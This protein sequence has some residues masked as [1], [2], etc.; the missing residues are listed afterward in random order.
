MEII[1]Q[2]I[3]KNQD[4]VQSSDKCVIEVPESEEERGQAEKYLKG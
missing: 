3:K 4:I 1:I 2:S